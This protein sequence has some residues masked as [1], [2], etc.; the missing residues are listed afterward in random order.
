MIAGVEVGD[1]EA[2]VRVSGVGVA[3]E[4]SLLSHVDG[5]Q[6]EQPLRL[7]RRRVG[8]ASGQ[9]GGRSAVLSGLRFTGVK[10]SEI[11]RKFGSESLIVWLDKTCWL[12]VGWLNISAVQTKSTHHL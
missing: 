11:G 12:Q 7:R 3:L 2:P 10:Q 1:E 6:R 5:G 8:R 4:K 9:R